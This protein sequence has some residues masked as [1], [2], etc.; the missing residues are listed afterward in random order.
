[1]EEPLRMLLVGG[2]GSRA[3][4]AFPDGV[5]VVRV[6]SRRYDGNRSIQCALATLRKGNVDLVV[7]LVR[8][9]GHPA[10]DALVAACKRTGVPLI[11][12]SGGASSAIRAVALHLT[13]V[14]DG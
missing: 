7:L 14:A 5:D 12:V 2:D 3:F 10:H 6:S 9:L 8:W 1:M 4:P 11:R 13:E